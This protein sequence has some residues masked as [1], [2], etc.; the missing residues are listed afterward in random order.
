MGET[1]KLRVLHFMVKDVQYCLDIE[2]IERVM[3]LMA[4]Q[5]VPG[6]P[7][8]V[9]GLM[10]LHG[11]SVPVLDVM[12]RAGL[13]PEESYGMDTPMLLC[14]Y[15]NAQ[16]GLIVSRVIGVESAETVGPGDKSAVESTT[17]PVTGVINTERGLSLML[18]IKPLM[19]LDVSSYTPD[20]G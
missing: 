11:K 16:A 12:I 6:G 15:Q 9:A 5:A 1:P 10:N 3:F 17:L 13:T 20:A 19:E 4:L 18:D 8:D 7:A 14:R 2:H